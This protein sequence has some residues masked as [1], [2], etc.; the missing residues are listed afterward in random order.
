MSPWSRTLYLTVLVMSVLLDAFVLYFPVEAAP[1]LVIGLLLVPIILWAGIRFEVTA[2]DAS[3]SRWATRGRVF[4]ELR[5][6]VV[7]LLE[8]V[9]RLNWIAVD[10]ERGFRNQDEAMR[11]MDDIE[12]EI[13]EIITDVRRAAGRPTV[14][15]EAG[16]V[17]ER[18]RRESGSSSGR[19]R[20][21]CVSGGHAVWIDYHPVCEGA[22]PETPHTPWQ[23]C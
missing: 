21:A 14:E 22:P 5:S 16:I 7:L 18:D 11:E 13:R 9:R 8:H 19:R 4:R 12:T 3:Q 1:R 15:P 6:Q 10:A 17:R 20:S 23:T 2:M